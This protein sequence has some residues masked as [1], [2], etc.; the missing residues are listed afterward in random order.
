MSHIFSYGCSS[1]A[2]D[3]YQSPLFCATIVLSLLFPFLG[4]FVFTSHSLPFFRLDI[5]AGVELLFGPMLLGVLLSTALYG[6]MTVQI[7]IYFQTYK[8]DASWIRYLILYLLFAETA[9]LVFEIGIIYEPLIVRYG[10]LHAVIVSPKL[11]PADA[12]SIVMV[13]TPVQ[14]FTAW[15]ISVITGSIVP[16]LLISVLSIASFGGGLLVTVFVSIR[17]EFAQFQSFRGA[18]VLWLVCSAVC[19]VFITGM[20][21]YSLY[22][23]KTGLAVDGQINR[24]I[25]LTVQTGADAEQR[26]PNALFNESQSQS[27]SLNTL[28]SPMGVLQAQTGTAS[29]ATLVAAHPTMASHGSATKYHGRPQPGNVRTLG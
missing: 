13:S 8:K 16:T 27:L 4:E 9:N 22:T 25:R 18:V 2:L 28:R 12:I 24:I 6:V 5:M 19:D 20:L 1:L 15:R 21:T 7:F 10:A 14:L 17:T 11:L 3:L 26:L 23:R 29:S